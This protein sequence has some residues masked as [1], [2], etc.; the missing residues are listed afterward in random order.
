MVL[1]HLHQ[2][3]CLSSTE[4]IVPF[5]FLINALCLCLLIGRLIGFLPESVTG[6]VPL[7]LK[8]LLFLG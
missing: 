1:A 5:P 2:Q 3:K 6:L 8:D 4:V 7:T